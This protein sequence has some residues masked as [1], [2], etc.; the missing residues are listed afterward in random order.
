MQG[1]G[2]HLI[3]E[4]AVKPQEIKWA[5]CPGRHSWLVAALYLR[6]RSPGSLCRALSAPFDQ[7]G[8]TTDNTHAWRIFHRTT[9]IWLQTYQCTELVFSRFPMV[10]MLPSSLHT[11]LTQ[12][13]LLISI[14]QLST[15]WSISSLSP[16]VK[17]RCWTKLN[18][19]WFA[20]VITVLGRLALGTVWCRSSDRV[21]KTAFF[22]YISW[23]Y[24]LQIGSI[25]I[26]TLPS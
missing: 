9:W 22:I 20:H 15:P 13:K 4:A 11:F 23:L 6:S 7:L 17:I 18:D 16:L 3:D 26:H 1:R 21:T 19:D 24:F 8:A 10:P 14:L 12:F 25:L 2:N 5:V